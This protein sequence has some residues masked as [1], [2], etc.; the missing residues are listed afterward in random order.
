M[1]AVRAAWLVRA[2]PVGAPLRVTL[3]GRAV[4]GHFV[5]LDESGALLLDTAE[6]RQRIIAG[7]VAA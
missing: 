2:H 4:T 7:D 6:G 3:D 5:G 1:R